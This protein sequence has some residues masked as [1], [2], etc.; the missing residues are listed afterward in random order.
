MDDAHCEEIG[1][2]EEEVGSTQTE[3]NSEINELQDL[4]NQ[5]S[6]PL[7]EPETVEKP[8]YLNDGNIKF[9]TH[10]NTLAR[11]LLPMRNFVS[12]LI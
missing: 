8:T 11:T 3:A 5:L 7:E 1:G 10:Q 4:L 6:T 2:N 12:N 9:A